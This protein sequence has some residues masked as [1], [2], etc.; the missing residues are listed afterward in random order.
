MP[1][2][3]RDSRPGLAIV[4]NVITPYRANLHRLIARGIPELK[5]HTLITHGPADFDWNLDIPPEINLS[6]HGTADDD[7][8][9]TLHHAPLR[10]W[11]K[12]GRLID[13]LRQHNVRV[14]V[15]IV[16]RY[17]SYVRMVLYCRRAGVP[18]FVNSDANIRSE[19]RI[20]PLEAAIKSRF[21]G[22]WIRR[23]AGVFP[24][25]DLGEQ[26]FL[27]YGAEPQRMYRVP[28]TPDY[29]RYASVQRD[30]LKEFCRTYGLNPAR[31]YFM[32]SGRL[33]PSKRVDLLIDAF[34]RIADERPDWDLV[35]VG[36]GVLNHELRK[37]VPEQLRKRVVWT[38]FLDGEEPTVAYHAAD[39]LVLPSD[40]EPW[41]L[42]VQEAMAAGLAVVASDVVGAAHELIDDGVSGRIFA[43]GDVESL[44]RA[45][46][47]VTDAGRLD[48]YKRQSRL[49]LQAWRQSLD[50]VAE[51]RRALVDAGALPPQSP[52]RPQ[53]EM[54]A[55]HG[56]P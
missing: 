56:K 39:V 36:D 7:P 48:E 47:D 46:L 20:S 24:M 12:G 1:D 9:A 11:H 17:L 10:E 14:V 19:R 5:L 33:A 52:A 53:L 18:V 50:P 29:D 25:G 41:A 16:P 42:V 4:A 38:G 22:W 28:Y 26:Y 35:V 51:I 49:A 8:I 3:S 2:S 43:A 31:R 21:H 6:F 30:R 13:Y 27:R 23:V 15:C 44:C 37:R 45:L 32:Y 54:G 34:A 40:R 55:V